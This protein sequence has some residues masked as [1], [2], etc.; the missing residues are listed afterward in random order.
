MMLPDIWPNY[1]KKAKGAEVWGLDGKKYIDMT[2]NG[3]GS[4]ILG[5]AD[6]DVNKAVKK[7]VDLGTMSTLNCPEEVE[8]SDILCEIHP[9]ADMVRYARTGGEAMAVAIR[10]ARAKTGK[11][12]IAFCGYHGWHDW[13]IAANLNSDDALEGHSI[14]GLSPIGV[15]KALKGTAFPFHY[16]KIDELKKILEENKGGMAAIAME[17][18]RNIKPEPGFIEA[19]KEL[20]R[21]HNAILIFDEIT[22]AWRV[23]EGGYHLNFNVA[24]DIAVFGKAMSNGYPM[25]AVIGRK[26][27]MEAAQNTFISSTYWSEKIGPTAAIATI[28]KCRKLNVPK[29]LAAAGEKV[30]DGWEKAGEATGVDIKVSGKDVVPSLAHFNFNYKN[31][32][33]VKT[34]FTQLMLDR[35]YLSNNGYYAT[36][37]HTDKIIEKY[38]ETVEEAFAGLKKHIEANEVEEKLRGEVAHMGFQRLN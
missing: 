2:H 15:P 10:I 20:A 11:D 1:Y 5:F 16:N 6:P 31:A 35:G 32:Q 28:E 3:V 38:L 19:V 37:A 29:H 22:A 21:Q 27:V 18:I 24:P 23:N 25:A 14:G 33:A 7:A 12:K 13:Y 36:Y 26:E 30:I 34:L 17:P 8:L 9:W 4:C